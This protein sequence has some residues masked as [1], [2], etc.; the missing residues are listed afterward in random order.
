MRRHRGRIEEKLQIQRWAIAGLQKRHEPDRK[1]AGHALP[2]QIRAGQVGHDPI[3][4]HTAV[5]RPRLPG[6]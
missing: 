3:E 1:I 4:P 2:E 6:L 5:E